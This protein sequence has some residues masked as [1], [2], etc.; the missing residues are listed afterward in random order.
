MKG[1]HHGGHRDHGGRFLALRAKRNVLL[2]SVT[3]VPFSVTSVP[4][5]VNS[6]EARA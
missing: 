2:F 6:F 3:S 1:F 5:V 4:S